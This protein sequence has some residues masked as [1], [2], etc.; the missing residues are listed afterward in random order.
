MARKTQAARAD[1]R[2]KLI[3]IADQA[4]GQ[5]G[6]SAIKARPLAAEAG[7]AVGAIYN[8]FGDLNELILAVN[9][10]TFA[11]LGA[12]VGEAVQPDAKPSDA[13]ITLGK[14][15]LAFAMNHP[16]KWRALFDVEL[17]EDSD[18]PDWYR[19][20]LARLF[21]YIAAPVRNLRPEFSD[22]DVML[23]TRS[24]FSSIHGIVW[25]GLENRVSGVP[26]DQLERMIEMVL[27]EFSK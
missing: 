12:E 5:D 18:V 20:E 4:I 2:A 14:A 23:M 7:C 19:D 22:T 16:R 17:T 27:T 1:L 8:V 21:G 25:L 6:I 10:R 26:K 13:L 9:M 3:D 15:Y 24:L 11:A